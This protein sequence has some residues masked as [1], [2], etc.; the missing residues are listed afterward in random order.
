MPP[1]QTNSRLTA[2]HTQ[3]TAPDWDRPGNGGAE[4]WAGDERAYYRESRERITGDAGATTAVLMR[5]LIIGVDGA[6]LEHIDNDD[7][8]TFELDTGETMTATA[9]TITT[10]RLAGLSSSIQTSRIVLDD[11]PAPE[12]D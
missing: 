5:T 6:A 2:V 12:T 7:V 8:L 10:A 9:R 3:A 4:K 11:A 1:L